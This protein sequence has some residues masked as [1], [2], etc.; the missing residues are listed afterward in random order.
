MYKLHEY[1]VILRMVDSHRYAVRG[2]TVA[3][4]IDFLWTADWTAGYAVRGS[5]SAAAIDFL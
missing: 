4:A 5:T 2:S 1:L 3:A